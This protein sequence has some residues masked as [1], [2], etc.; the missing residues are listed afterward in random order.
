MKRDY[1]EVLGVERTADENVI[2][3]A[4][5][6]LAKKYHPDTNKGNPEAEE[7]FKEAT[8]AYAVL[9]DPEKR[10]QYD[11]FGFG[12]PTQNGHYQE[13]HFDDADMDDILKQFFGGGFGNFHRGYEY[14]SSP[15]KGEDIQANIEVSFVEA[16][17]GCEKVVRLTD[18]DGTIQSLK[19][20]I[21]AGIDTG[22][23]I[24]LQGKGQPGIRGGKAGDM[25][26][27]V[28]VKETPEFERKGKDI[29]STIR[30][31]YTTAVF[32]GE[33]IVRTL[34]GKVLCKISP[35]TQ[36]G[37]KIRLKGKGIVSM[38]HPNVYG[39]HYVTIQIDVPKRVSRRAQEK[40]REFEKAL[41]E[42][43]GNVAYS[44]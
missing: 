1:Y 12:Q 8:E 35:G 42:E 14:R 10:K 18:Q 7:K 44:S 6:K 16:A 33:S 30:I 39:D 24:R 22:Q 28:M 40:L 26:L 32:G 17:N 38:K 3:R 15:Q 20:R 11:Q 21:P 9:S 41:Q 31:P 37:T 25:F 29:Y 27:K 19:V 36:S 5:R 43:G 23:S 13:F 2:K 34:T 4:Y